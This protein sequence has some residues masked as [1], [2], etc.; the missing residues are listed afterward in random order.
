MQKL[1]AFLKQF[2]DRMRTDVVALYT[3]AAP[4]ERKGKYN[5]RHTQLTL[6]DVKNHLAGTPAIGLYMLDKELGTQGLCRIACVD[7]D[8]KE[9]KCTWEQLVAHGKTISDLLMKYGLLSWPCR[10]GSG[11][12][13]HLWL[14]WTEPQSASAVRALLKEL[15][16][17]ADTGLHID[18]FPAQN[19]TSE[20][21]MGSLVALPFSRESRPIDLGS[22]Q[23]L[24]LE[25]W[26]P[27]SVAMSAP[28]RAPTSSEPKKDKQ[29]NGYGTVDI[30][31]LNEALKHIPND[32]YESWMRMGM[33]LKQGI[34]SG[35]IT[36]EVGQAAWYEWSKTD[37]KFDEREQDYQ[38]K[39]LQPDGSLTMGTIWH[40]AESNGW[41]PPKGPVQKNRETDDILN[42]N[43]TH[44]L[45]EEG[46]RMAIF[47][48]EWDDTLKRDVLT[49]LN[50]SDFKLK[51]L[52]QK[53]VVGHS[54]KGVPVVED[55]GTAWLNSEHRRQYDRIVLQPEG[56]PSNLYNLWKG[57]SVEPSEA[58]SCELLKEH[59]FKNLCCDNK[60]AYEFLLSWCAQ[61]VQN[62]QVPIGSAIVLRGGKGTGKGT[63]ARA[64]GDLFGQH[65]Q[66]I[67]RGTSLTGNF[68]K[69]LRDCILMYADEAVWAGSKQES[70]VLSGLITEPYLAIEGK[71]QDLVQCRNM[72]HLIIATNSEWSAPA[73]M[74]ER[75]YLCLEVSDDKKQDIAYFNAI[76]D[77]LKRGG[78]ARFL[79]ELLN[80]NL[81]NFNGHVVP[82]TEELARQKI[83][84]LD[85]W[86]EWWYEKL[87][88][89][90]IT[91]RTSEWGADHASIAVYH[92]YVQ[93]CRLSGARNAK[94][95]EHL[96]RSLGKLLPKEMTK[97]RYRLKTDL[98][99]PLDTFTPGT[100]MTFWKFPPLQ[101]CREFFAQKARA[102]LNWDTVQEVISEQRAQVYDDKPLL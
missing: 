62:P 55:L 66:Q 58:G 53:V 72:L 39:K 99:T 27:A 12:G 3:P 77:Q 52:N 38:W 88:A 35:Q 24:S 17:K 85:P 86:A 87:C 47:R 28:V 94:S 71:G 29:P 82:Q 76:R 96:S 70:S 57:W 10:S 40:L 8:D 42:L 101:Q 81:E 60:E 13:V 64:L 102:E 80:R 48:E 41:K 2:T 7:L 16:T 45:C 19:A 33:A 74:D 51:F 43:Q 65:Y 44:F 100:L 73:G 21:N 9:K 83:L 31:T 89:G 14:F 92:D 25:D 63:F 50:A 59:M 37:P 79:W 90:Q 84:S 95:S 18:I 30:T 78:S 54:K 4:G 97:S 46:N 49:R 36:E 34:A 5:P 15:V 20:T 56:A 26:T 11:H 6:Q 67:F 1:E 68:N 98:I 61:T 69:H 23:V 91:P 75:R 22:A 93:H 32:N